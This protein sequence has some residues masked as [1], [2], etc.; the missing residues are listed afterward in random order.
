[1]VRVA[2]LR[3]LESYFRHR[4]LYLLPMLI[5]LAAGGAFVATTPAEYSASGK[6]FVEKTNLLASLTSTNTDSS[7]W[8]SPAQLTTNEFNELLGTDAFL[9]SVVKGTKLEAQIANAAFPLNEL[10]T[11]LRQSLYAT[12]RGDKLVEITATNTDPELAYQLVAAT[13]DAYV[14]WKLNND[15]RESVVAQN[16]FKGLIEPYQKDLETA[17]A[18]LLAYLTANPK[19]LGQDRPVEEQFEIDRLQK[20]VDRA[21][22]RLR[23][24]QQNEENAQFSQKKSESLTNQ[25]YLSIDKPE[26]PQTSTLSVKKIAINVGIFAAVGVFLCIAGIVAGALI[27]RSL[28]FSLDAHHALGLRVLAMLP[29]VTGANAVTEAMVAGQTTAETNTN[30]QTDSSVLQPQI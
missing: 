18:S 9:R 10:F 13:M 15:Y 24:A 22:E 30:S 8:V 4:W 3:L 12:P 29:T 26:I 6:L 5:A 2:L 21:D 1:M 7:W 11:A 28:R 23:T 17:R 16:F 25:T 27:D 20:E 19:K 14:Q